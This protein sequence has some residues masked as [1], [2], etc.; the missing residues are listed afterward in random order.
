M[1]SLS[2]LIIEQIDKELDVYA[3]A[4]ST[5]EHLRHLFEGYRARVLGEDECPYAPGTHNHVSWVRGWAIA[6]IDE[7]AA[8]I[9]H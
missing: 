3:D 1:S 7:R 8:A 9:P 4:E 6:G 5:V 2:R